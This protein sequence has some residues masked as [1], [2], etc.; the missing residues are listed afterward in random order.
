MPE[1]DGLT[2]FRK[3]GY[4]R[5]RDAEHLLTPPL[6][7]REENGASLRHLRGAMY[8]CGYGVECLFKAYM[9]A[10]HPPLNRLSD[11][12]FELRK[13][14]PN[15]RDIC[16]VAGHDLSYLLTL[17][18]LETRMDIGRKIQMGQCAKWRSSWRYSA[19]PAREDD[20]KAMVQAARSLVTW[21]NSQI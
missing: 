12:L 7:D 4:Q 13:A 18:G 2:T 20:A 17:T 16:G 19:E 6:V 1:F 8:L 9:I 11:V 21:I 10:Q 5:L 15:V 3:S 14:D